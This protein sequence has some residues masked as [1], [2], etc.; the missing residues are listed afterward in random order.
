LWLKSFSLSFQSDSLIVHRA[1]PPQNDF[2]ELPHRDDGDEDE[3]PGR[4]D[5]VEETG[6]EPVAEWISSR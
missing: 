3:E 2:E 6:P 4:M 5:I 1:H